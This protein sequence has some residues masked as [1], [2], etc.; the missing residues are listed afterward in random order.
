MLDPTHPT[1]SVSFPAHVGQMASSFQPNKQRLGTELQ[2]L[3]QVLDV[4][5]APVSQAVN[6]LG[7]P[8]PT[9]PFVPDGH[10]SQPQSRG[11]EV[12]SPKATGLL[13]K[14]LPQ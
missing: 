8:V 11:G 14:I 9:S 7:A 10:P 13:M 2:S 1:S 6:R 12:N 4:N 3:A 5:M